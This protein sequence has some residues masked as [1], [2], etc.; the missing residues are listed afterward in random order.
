MKDEGRAP[1]GLDPVR[2]RLPPQRSRWG[3]RSPYGHP[4]HDGAHA[5]PTYG[6][7]ESGG[8]TYGCLAPAAPDDMHVFRD[9]HAVIQTESGH[10]LLTRLFP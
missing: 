7:S 3:R 8:L 10:Q 1:G 5:V 4:R 9:R 6:L 2:D